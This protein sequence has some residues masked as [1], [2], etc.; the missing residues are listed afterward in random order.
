MTT[1]QLEARDRIRSYI[2]H[3]AAKEPASIRELVEKGH[4]QVAGL[5]DGLSEEQATFKPSPDDWSVL[6]VL[7]HVVSAK[8]GVARLCQRLGRGERVA[9]FGGEG[10]EQDGVTGGRP[11]ATLGEARA[12]MDAAHRALLDFVDGPIATANVET[13]FAHFLFGELNCREWAAFQRVHDGDHAGQI[14]KVLAAPG[15][16]T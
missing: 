15:F 7:H 13:R 1:E 16:P 10:Q 8:R 9:G 6:E 3:N 2:Q 4:A 5:I 11:F 12:A 14:E